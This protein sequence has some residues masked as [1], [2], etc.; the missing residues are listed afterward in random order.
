MNKSLNLPLEV[1]IWTGDGVKV[2][3]GTGCLGDWCLCLQLVRDQLVDSCVVFTGTYTIEVK[4]GEHVACVVDEKARRLSI[5]LNEHA[6]ECAVGYFM[7]CY[8]DGRGEVDHVDVETTEGRYL[9]LSYEVGVRP[10]K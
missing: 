1:D 10:R 9:T 4:H 8:R 6:I 2:T 5:T 3:V 7:R